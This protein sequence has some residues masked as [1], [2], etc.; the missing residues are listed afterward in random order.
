MGH[1]G[2]RATASAGISRCYAPRCLATG[3]WSRSGID[4]L[5]EDGQAL[6]VVVAVAAVCSGSCRAA[7]LLGAG[8]I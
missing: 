7:L 8:S 3:G 2:E 5:L 4:Q 6:V 1:N